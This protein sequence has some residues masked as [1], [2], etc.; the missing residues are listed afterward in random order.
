M[1]DLIKR[2]K[3]GIEFSGMGPSFGLSKV[4]CARLS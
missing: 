2:L 4:T 1:L 3:D